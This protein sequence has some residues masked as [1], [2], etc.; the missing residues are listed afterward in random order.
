MIS[1]YVGIDPGINCGLAIWRPRL[2]N[3]ECVRSVL[4]WE[5]IA[6]LIAL[7]NGKTEVIIEDPQQNKTVWTR[8]GTSESM[9]KKIAQDVGR[10]KGYARLI[11]EWCEMTG[12]PNQVI[13]PKYRPR[14]RSVNTP[15]KKPSA[16]PHRPPMNRPIHG[17]MP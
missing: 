12:M 4:F 11:I 14:R 1:R 8:P 6:C 3:F 17:L 13:R 16:A 15:V 5:L 2:R 9:M 7:D 10:N